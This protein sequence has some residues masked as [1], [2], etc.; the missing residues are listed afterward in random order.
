MENSPLT[1]GA[2][3]LIADLASRLGTPGSPWHDV[4]LIPITNPDGVLIGIIS[5]AD[6][7]AALEAAPAATVLEAGVLDPVTIHA[8]DLLSDAV[9]RMI[10]HGIGRLPV[11]DHSLAPKLIGLLTRRAI[12]EAKHHQLKMDLV[13]LG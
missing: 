7:I 1:V 8:D 4:R 12:L 2:Q 6:L 13:P 5:R 10:L 9:D 3:E 11:V